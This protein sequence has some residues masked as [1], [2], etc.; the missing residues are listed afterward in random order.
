MP[1]LI[2]NNNRVIKKGKMA[3]YSYNV[4]WDAKT[5]ILAQMVNPIHWDKEG[6]Y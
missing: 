2:E 6:I 1:Y 5:K 4:K 3:Y